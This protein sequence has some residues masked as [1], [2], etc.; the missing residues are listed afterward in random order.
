MFVSFFLGCHFAGPQASPSKLL[1]KDA[2]LPL[3]RKCDHTECL[4]IAWFETWRLCIQIWFM[5]GLNLYMQVIISLLQ[6]PCLYMLH[7]AIA[8]CIAVNKSLPCLLFV[9]SELLYQVLKLKSFA[10]ALHSFLSSWWQPCR[11]NP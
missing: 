9:P 3:V 8:T 7:P 6:E 2:K 11:C 5:A 4:C 10:R 1:L